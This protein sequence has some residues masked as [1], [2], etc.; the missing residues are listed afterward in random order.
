M[1]ARFDLESTRGTLLNSKRP[2]DNTTANAGK[3]PAVRKNICDLW[4]DPPVE[5]VSARA[6]QKVGTAGCGQPSL[7]MPN[8]LSPDT[9]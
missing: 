4:H 3:A 9:P 6:G 8:S 5:T 7:Y 1:V 2:Y